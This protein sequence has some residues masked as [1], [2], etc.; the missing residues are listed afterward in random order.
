MTGKINVVQRGDAFT[1]AEVK[2]MLQSR[3][4][5]MYGARLDSMI[6]NFRAACERAETMDQLRE[7]QGALKAL[8]R[9][10]ELPDVILR[11]LA[12]RRD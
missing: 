12:Q 3:A 6:E 9:A 11:E 5:N 10:K 7:A 2:D 1:A 8:R 4:W